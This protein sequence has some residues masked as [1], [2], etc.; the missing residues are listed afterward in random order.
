MRFKYS[1][2]DRNEYDRNIPA[3][4]YCSSSRSLHVFCANCLWSDKRCC[5]SSGFQ[6]LAC[7]QTYCSC[8]KLV[9]VS[10]RLRDAIPINRDSF[11]EGVRGSATK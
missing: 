2:D 1:E 9:P 5:K 10:S 3:R 8:A 6:P 4:S 11:N 7:G